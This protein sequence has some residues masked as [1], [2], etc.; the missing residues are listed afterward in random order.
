MI[1][2]DLDEVLTL[3]DRIAVMYE[4]SIVGEVEART[5]RRR[6]RLP[7]PGLETALSPGDPPGRRGA[8]RCSGDRSVSLPEVR[9]EKR[10]HQR[11]W[12]MVAVPSA[13]SSSRT[14]PIAVLLTATGHSPPTTFRRLFDA[15]F[16][17]DGA[18][19]TLYRGDA[20]G[21][22]PGSPRRSAFRMRLFNIGAE[23][24]LYLGAIGSA[25]IGPAPRRSTSA[26]R[27][28]VAMVYRGAPLPRAAWGAIPGLLRAFLHTNEIIT[29]LM[30]NYVAALVLNYLIFDSLSYWRDQSAHGSLRVP[31]GKSPGRRNVAGQIGSTPIPLGFL[32]AVA[33]PR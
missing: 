15:A 12:L 14:Q 5:N 32:L 21:C 16:P 33:A 24:Q 30:L 10:L 22:S 9:I 20:A 13:L 31:A 18:L 7:W 17:A 3:S 25:G 8:G 26:G 4:G 27:L 23:G 29:S 28:V 19:E 11:R 2:E 1:S 6:D